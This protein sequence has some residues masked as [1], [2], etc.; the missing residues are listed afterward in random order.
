MRSASVGGVAKHFPG[1]GRA[2]KGLNTDLVPVS[3][4]ETEEELH[5]V[6]IPQFIDAIVADFQMIM[7]SW[8]T[9][10]S[11]DTKRPA[12]LSPVW[13]KERLRKE[14]EFRGLVL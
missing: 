8:A 3:I 9:Y 10:P 2:S 14:R 11:V 12:G 7:P 13:L 4:N 6:D 5:V 1:L